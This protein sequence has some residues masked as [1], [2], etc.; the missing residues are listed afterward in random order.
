[1]IGILSTIAPPFDREQ[2]KS[3]ALWAATQAVLLIQ[4]HK[5][6]YEVLVNA[7]EEGSELGEC[8]RVI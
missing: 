2:I 1:M 3:Q 7:L 8:V 5:E 4:E 6:A